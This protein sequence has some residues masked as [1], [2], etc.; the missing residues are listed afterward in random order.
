MNDWQSTEVASK[1]PRIDPNGSS[2]PNVG[3]ERPP[4]RSASSSTDEVHTS[5]GKGKGKEVWRVNVNMPT[6][7][8]ENPILPKY[9]WRHWN[10]E[11]MPPEQREKLVQSMKPAEKGKGKPTASIPKPK[12]KACPSCVCAEA[13]ATSCF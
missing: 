11:R 9:G 13:K 2:T 12:A 7:R 3:A 1:K 5:T 8:R 10:L 6:R 4:P